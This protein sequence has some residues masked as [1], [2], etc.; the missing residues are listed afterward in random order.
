MESRKER[1]CNFIDDKILYETIIGKLAKSNFDNTYNTDNNTNCNSNVSNSVTNVNTDVSNTTNNASKSFVFQTPTSL[2]M[3]DLSSVN[4]SLYMDS[5]YSLLHSPT[6]SKM[7]K[8]KLFH[9]RTIDEDNCLSDEETSLPNSGSDLSDLASY[10]N[11]NI[12]FML[13][14]VTNNSGRRVVPAFGWKLMTNNQ[15]KLK[16]LGFI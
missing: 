9:P 8:K 10:P 16:S 15:K 11:G 13:Q 12:T 14:K 2:K 7:K 5:D 3:N 4:S 6:F 1:F